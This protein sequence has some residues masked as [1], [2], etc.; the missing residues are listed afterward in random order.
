MDPEVYRSMS[1]IMRREFP[2]PELPPLPDVE[3][4]QEQELSES[5]KQPRPAAEASWIYKGH[6]MDTA[7]KV[8]QAEQPPPQTNL[9]GMRWMSRT[10]QQPLM[11]DGGSMESEN[12]V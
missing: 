10:Q 2:P 12:E 7:H 6:I 11:W 4:A 5:T 3:Q 9:Q 8:A 1:D